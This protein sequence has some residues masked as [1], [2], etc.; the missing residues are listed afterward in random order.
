MFM[1]ITLGLCGRSVQGSGQGKYW[2]ESV[3][4]TS[5]CWEFTL[6]RSAR[7]LTNRQRVMIDRT[8]KM[9]TKAMMRI[10]SQLSRSNPTSSS[11]PFPGPA[12]ALGAGAGPGLAA[13]TDW[14]AQVEL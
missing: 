14:Q 6:R 10:I 1:M 4:G 8:S 3:L 2:P 7:S 13:A 9:E 5:D 11:F 12:P